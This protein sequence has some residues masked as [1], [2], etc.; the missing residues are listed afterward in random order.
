MSK[1]E[2]SSTVEECLDLTPP[3]VAGQSGLLEAGGGG[4]AMCVSCVAGERMCS[5][6][7]GEDMVV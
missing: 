4:E 1:T 6:S 3:F 2:R 5:T 7:T